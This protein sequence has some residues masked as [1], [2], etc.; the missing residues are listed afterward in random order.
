MIRPP[1]LSVVAAAALLVE[2]VLPDDLLAA[3]MVAEDLLPLR[4]RP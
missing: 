2:G 1:G 4:L 3:G